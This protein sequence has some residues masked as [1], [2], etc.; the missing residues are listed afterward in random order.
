MLRR[1]VRGS[2]LAHTWYPGRVRTASTTARAARCWRKGILCPSLE[3]S[4]T[5]TLRVNMAQPRGL[6]QTF[7]P[8]PVGAAN[9]GNVQEDARWYQRLIAYIWQIISIRTNINV[10]WSLW[11]MWEHCVCRLIV[12]WSTDLYPGFVEQLPLIPPY[13]LASAE[14][15]WR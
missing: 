15:A 3:L 11:C 5:W 9:T 8:R 10:C 14:T 13:L 1:L 6:S 4:S 2:V 7:L 12:C